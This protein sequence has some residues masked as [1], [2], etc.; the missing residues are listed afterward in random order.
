LGTKVGSQHHTKNDISSQQRKTKTKKNYR[1]EIQYILIT[2]D[3]AFQVL[4]FGM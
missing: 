1:Q 3:A 2:R 4:Q